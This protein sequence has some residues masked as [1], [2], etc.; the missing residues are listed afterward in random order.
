MLL[1]K[2]STSPTNPPQKAQQHEIKCIR[3]HPSTEIG[4]RMRC[5]ASKH[6]STCVKGMFACLLEFRFALS[7][8]LRFTASK[9]S[10]NLK[11]SI[12]SC[13]RVLFSLCCLS[14]SDSMSV[15][16]GFMLHTVHSAK[17]PHSA[18]SFS[19]LWFGI[20]RNS[21]QW[22]WSLW[23][24]FTRNSRVSDPNLFCDI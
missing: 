14:L 23:I 19:C 6:S 12:C 18:A 21:T 11:S 20:K 7:H 2:I 10:L 16:F 5:E 22:I 24:S 3:F 8:P 13:V 1:S 9:F 4:N 15:N 17:Y